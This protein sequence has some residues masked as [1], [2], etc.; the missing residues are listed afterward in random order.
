MHVHILGICGT[1]M[2]GIAALAREMGHTV[3]GSDQNVYPPMSTQLEQLGI[4]LRSGYA[5]AH[6]SA[7]VDSVVV[8][9]ALSRGNAAVEHVLNVG[10]SYTSGAQWLSEH[11]LPGRETFAVAGTHGKTTTTSLLAFLLDAAGRDPGFLVGGVPENFGVSA[12]LGSGREFVVEA[13]EYDTAFF[14]KRS[15]F[16]HYRP[17]VAVLNNL[18]YDHADIFPDLAAIQRQF[19]HLV[20]IVPGRGRLI[21]NGEDAALAE[22]LAM[23]C[24]TPVERFGIEHADGSPEVAPVH[25]AAYDWS[26]RLLSAD[27][28]RFEVRR[29]GSL[30]G[31]VEWPLLGRHNVMNAL[32]ALAAAAAAGCDATALLPAFARFA[33]AKRRL[34]VVGVARGVTVYDDFAH[35]PTA[36][37]TTLEGLRAKVGRARVIAA[38]EPRSNSMRLGAH[39]EA[40]APSLDPADATVFL[41][42]PNLP[43]DAASVVSVVRGEAGTVPDV[44]AMIAK[45]VA[46]VRDGDHVV[47]MS[48]GGFEDAPRRFLAALNR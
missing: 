19:H 44:D 22:V 45:L 33:S 35:H 48:N 9:N 5:P 3:E 24:W 28:S 7:G 15:K 39:A 26:A 47:F 32:A 10:M 29:A 27:G 38:L 14:D 11:V 30:L 25:A 16:V 43:W 4:A 1:F 36:I 12:R 23:G 18:E 34:E 46:D 41:H 20:R 40:L 17:T 8:G 42:R 31:V 2:G 21:V 6:I 37:R 13:D